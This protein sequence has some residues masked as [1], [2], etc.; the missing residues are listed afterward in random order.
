MP[1]AGIIE[2]LE[3][4]VPG[5][6]STRLDDA[7]QT[8][9]I[10]VG[11]VDDTAFSAKT[12][13]DVAPLDVGMAIAQCRQAKASI[14]LGVFAV[15]DAKRSVPKGERS[16]RAHAP[17][18]DW[19]RPR[20]LGA[21]LAMRLR[22]GAVPRHDLDRNRRILPQGLGGKLRLLV[23]GRMHCHNRFFISDEFRKGL[24]DIAKDQRIQRHGL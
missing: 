21:E 9:I 2:I 8:R 5:K 16:R 14:R 6:I 3:Q 19:N 22:P 20:F 18:A 12:Q 15:A 1:L 13:L 11:F 24:S 23:G 4:L 17:I 7:C 10:D